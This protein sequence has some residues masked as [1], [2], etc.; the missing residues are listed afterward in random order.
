MI[1]SGAPEEAAFHSHRHKVHVLLRRMPTAGPMHSGYRASAGSKAVRRFRAARRSVRLATHRRHHRVPLAEAASGPTRRGAGMG[2]GLF[3]GP[4]QLVPGRPPLPMR[5]VRSLTGIDGYLRISAIPAC[6]L[7]LQQDLTFGPRA[8]L[9][10]LQM[11][12]DEVNRKDCSFTS[13]FYRSAL[14]SNDCRTG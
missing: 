5:A 14:A 2:L 1:S 13:R 7:M 8:N 9:S 10:S 3:P 4:T 12:N 6:Q 11:I